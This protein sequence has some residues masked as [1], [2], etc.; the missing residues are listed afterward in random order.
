M[1]PLM[2]VSSISYAISKHFEPFSMDAKKLGES[3]KIF[4]NDKDRNILNT[5]NTLK[6]VEKD[7]QKISPN[8]KLGGI[9]EI[10]SKTQRNIFPVTDDE[11]KLLGIIILDNIREVIF[12]A[13]LYEKITANELMISP[14]AIIVST[15]TMEEVMR[16]FDKTGAWNLPVT[17]NGKYQGFI[18]KSSIFSS[19]RT[20]LKEATI[21]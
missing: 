12:K 4:T 18:S 11:D 7:F 14:P 15:E 13:N 5:I 6:L 1:I 19:Y 3:G 16:K 21:L 8:L 20:K 17:E 2:I 9:V 10:I